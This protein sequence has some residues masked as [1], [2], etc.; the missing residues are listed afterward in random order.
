VL[1]EDIQE[2]AVPVLAHRISLETRA[3]Y[4]GVARSEV[5]EKAL[6]TVPVPV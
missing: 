4:A 6:E 5:V 3:R 2:M 1:P